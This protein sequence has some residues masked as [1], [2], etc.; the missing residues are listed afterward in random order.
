MSSTE[1]PPLSPT[2]RQ[3]ELRWRAEI[4]T[5]RFDLFNAR[6]EDHYATTLRWMVACGVERDLALINEAS[7]IGKFR[8]AETGALILKAISSIRARAQA[9]QVNPAEATDAG[10]QGTATDCDEESFDPRRLKEWSV[11][12]AAAAEAMVR[13]SELVRPRDEAD[14]R[15]ALY[16]AN[17]RGEEEDLVLVEELERSRPF[18][19][20]DLDS[21]IERVKTSISSRLEARKLLE[22]LFNSGAIAVADDI[23]RLGVSVRGTGAPRG[24]LTRSAEQPTWWQDEQRANAVASLM[25]P[26]DELRRQVA[27]VLGEWGGEEEA[28]ALAEAMTREGWRTPE[29]EQFALYCIAGL[30]NIG[31]DPA[32][33]AL[34][35]ALVKGTVV[36]QLTALNA[37]EDLATGGSEVFGGGAPHFDPPRG[38][39]FRGEP[40]APGTEAITETLE[41]A[42]NEAESPSVR[43]RSRELLEHVLI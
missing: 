26:N 30:K 12:I 29:G 19:S 13:R 3:R 22:E 43:E 38:R 18:L 27:L 40:P 10:D 28:V 11:S 24:K 16:W 7:R 20:G 41:K 1:T 9:G 37:I 25:S 36:I 42:M 15:R 32:V 31:G 21:L 4:L 17:A 39:Y 5:R 35:N 14:C 34:C 6:D 23:V 8:S 33:G 2:E